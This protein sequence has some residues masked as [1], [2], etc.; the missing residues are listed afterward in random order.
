MLYLKQRKFIRKSAIL[1]CKEQAAVGEKY[2]GPMEQANVKKA[3]PE[4]VL[5]IA[6]ERYLGCNS[7]MQCTSNLL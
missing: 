4:W 5:T 1:I 3:I 7:Q 6:K 2:H